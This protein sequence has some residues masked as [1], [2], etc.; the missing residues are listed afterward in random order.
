MLDDTVG[1]CD[2]VCGVKCVFAAE[3]VQWL[4]VYQVKHRAQTDLKLKDF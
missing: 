4:S 1:F 3:L 2:A